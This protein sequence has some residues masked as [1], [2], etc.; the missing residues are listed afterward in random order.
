MALEIERKFLVNSDEWRKAEG[1]VFRQGYLSTHKERTVRVRVVDS[2]LEIGRLSVF[3][4]PGPGGGVR[5]EGGY[6]RLVESDDVLV[7][8][9]GILVLETPFDSAR[10]PDLAVG[11][12]LL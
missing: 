3:G 5:L 7:T 2:H 12:P 9:P 11:E 1:I 6:V 4:A 10:G 8:N